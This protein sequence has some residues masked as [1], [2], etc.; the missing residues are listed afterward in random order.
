MRFPTPDGRRRSAA[1]VRV[2]AGVDPF[3]AHQRRK[4][5]PMTDDSGSSTATPD[6][7]ADSNLE[8]FGYR[9]ELRRSLRLRDLIVYGLIFMV[10]IAPFAIFGPVFNASHGM[11]PLT[12]VI[13]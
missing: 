1:H 2:D 4:G 9:Q 12:Y 5:A 10:P 11:V 6:S 13:G 8:E 3:G 7:T